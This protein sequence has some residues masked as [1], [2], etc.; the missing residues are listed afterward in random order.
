MTARLPVAA[1][2]RT[3]ANIGPVGA[4]QAASHPAGVSAGNDVRAPGGGA[5]H[6]P[7]LVERGYVLGRFGGVP[8][9]VGPELAAQIKAIRQKPS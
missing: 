1:G 2:T 6:R 7:S 4:G 5:R 3:Q 8:V 9:F